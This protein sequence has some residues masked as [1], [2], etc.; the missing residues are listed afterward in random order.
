MKESRNLR[1]AVKHKWPKIL[2]GEVQASL[3]KAEKERGALGGEGKAAPESAGGIQEADGA[4]SRPQATKGIFT[5]ITNPA[6]PYF[7]QLHLE[8]SHVLKYSEKEF[9]DTLDWKPFSQ[10]PSTAKEWDS[11][12]LSKI[13]VIH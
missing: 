13:K 11:L 7:F 5:V 2:S 9:M 8:A 6:V 12:N 4:H 10:P 3:W 1:H